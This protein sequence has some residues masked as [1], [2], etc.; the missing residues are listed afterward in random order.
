MLLPY[1]HQH[2]IHLPKSYIEEHIKI[3]NQVFDEIVAKMSDDERTEFIDAMN[4]VYVMLK[5]Y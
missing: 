5:K 2:P 3:S 4:M 1:L